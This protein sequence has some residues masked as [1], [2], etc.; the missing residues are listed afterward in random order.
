MRKNYIVLHN[1]LSG[2][3]T[4]Y[5]FFI[6]LLLCRCSRTCDNLHQLASN[7]C[8]PGAVVQDLELANHFARILGGVVHGVAT[9]RDFAGITLSQCLFVCLVRHRWTAEVR[10]ECTQKIELASENS[11]RLGSCSSL[12]SKAEILA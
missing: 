12:I 9:G 5:I 6:P 2:D 7:H 3:T 10:E 8:L 4:L 1:S 11:R